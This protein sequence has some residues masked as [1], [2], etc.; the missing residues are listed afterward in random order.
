MRQAAPE[1]GTRNGNARP[2]VCRRGRLR[3]SRSTREGRAAAPRRAR[4]FT[5]RSTPL[6]HSFDMA[7]REPSSCIV[8]TV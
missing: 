4:Y 6:Y 2:L 3:R 5:V 8:F 7:L 1:G